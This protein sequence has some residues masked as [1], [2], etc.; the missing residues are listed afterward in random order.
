MTYGEPPL[1]DSSY[2]PPGSLRTRS[3]NVQDILHHCLQANP[4][5]RGSHNWL[6]QHPYTTNSMAL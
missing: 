2:P 4:R 5:H 6:A 1:E 3:P